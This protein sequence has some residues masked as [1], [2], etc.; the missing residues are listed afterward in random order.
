MLGIGLAAALI[1]GC[2]HPQVN[3]S[4]G[5]SNVQPR[6]SATAAPGNGA[7]D[8]D[9]GF[10]STID[11]NALGDRPPWK[12]FAPGIDT[13]E[14]ALKIPPDA[15]GNADRLILYVPHGQHRRHSLG[16]VFVAPR[17][18]RSLPAIRRPTTIAPSTCPT[19]GRAMRS[20]R[21]ISMERLTRRTKPRQTFRR[22]MRS[23]RP[24]P[25]ESSMARNT[26]EYVLARLP[27]V[28]PE[29]LYVAGHSSAAIWALLFA[30]HEPRIK[31]CIAYA[32]LA[33]LFGRA[34]GKQG[35]RGIVLSRHR[36]IVAAGRR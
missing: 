9:D 18:L 13:V 33:D 10:I 36:S 21:S 20:R 7:S 26:L 14:V 22:R 19:S 32:P 31:G 17:A 5:S 30:E 12:S 11:V 4:T 15:P 1:S 29:R 23:S 6:S 34:P 27:E 16:C 25:E 24:L 28:D 3:G 2:G 8:G 35:R